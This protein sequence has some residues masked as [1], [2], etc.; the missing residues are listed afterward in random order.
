MGLPTATDINE[1]NL[2]I[3]PQIGSIVYN[4]DDDQ[5]YR[6]TGTTNGWQKGIGEMSVYSGSFQITTAGSIT[7]SGLPF[8]PSNI[9]F[10]AHANVESFG[11]DTAGSDGTNSATIQNSFGTSNGFA[12][13]DSGTTIQETIYI[14]GSGSSIN[15][16]SRYSANDKCLG[17]RY[18]NQNGVNLGLITGELTNFNT[19]GFDINITYTNG[20]SGNANLNDDIQDEDLIVL[21]TAYK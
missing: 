14:G 20:V 1:M 15:S 18:G 9:T 19:D 4:L 3:A 12:R 2:I 21:Y 8:Q 17:V 16:I 5:I 13:D 6:Y 7:I 10:I 11:I